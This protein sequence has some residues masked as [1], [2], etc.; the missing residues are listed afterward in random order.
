MSKNL[1]QKLTGDKSIGALAV[2]AVET[3]Q[4]VQI[5]DARSA[6]LSWPC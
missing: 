2:Q 4:A 1:L 6:V 5:V 3:V